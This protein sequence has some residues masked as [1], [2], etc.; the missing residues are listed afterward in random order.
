MTRAETEH[1]SVLKANGRTFWL[2]SFLLDRSTADAAA[3]L[4]QFC[5]VLDDIADAG[6]RAESSAA[7]RLAAIRSHFLGQ[8]DRA[9]LL[10]SEDLVLAQLVQPLHVDPRIIVALIDG[11]LWDLEHEPFT[12]EAQLLRYSYRVAGTVGVLMSGLLGCERNEGRYHAIDLG[13][14][15]QLTNISRDVLEDAVMQR[16]YVPVAVDVA[17]LADARPSEAMQNALVTAIALSEKH[18]D[19]GIKGI[20]YLPRLVRPC[21]YLMA[22]LYRAISR[23]IVRNTYAWQR[24]RTTLSWFEIALRIFVSLPMCLWLTVL[25]GYKNGEMKHHAGLHDALSGLPGVNE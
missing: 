3:R 22:V 8:E 13:I 7:E 2:A 20:R 15:M 5:R 1:F 4:Y 25:P 16:R 14:G 23:K 24:G 11:L 12:S 10:S 21:V 6:E 18:Y 17:S 19:S 9:L